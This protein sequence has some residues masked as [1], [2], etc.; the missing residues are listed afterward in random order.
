MGE[1]LHQKSASNAASVPGALG[2][3]SVSGSF[4]DVRERAEPRSARSS[5]IALANDAT[6]KRARKRVSSESVVTPPSPQPSLSGTPLGTTTNGGPD[7]ATNPSMSPKADYS[8]PPSLRPTS[9]TC[10]WDANEPAAVNFANLGAVLA[11]AGHIYRDGVGGQGLLF[12]PANADLPVRR[13]TDGRQLA[14]LVVDHVLVTVK[15][16]GKDVRKA[17]PSGDL[18]LMLQSEAFLQAFEP[19]DMI[20]RA[21]I[22]LPGFKLVEPGYNDGGLGHRVFHRGTRVPRRLSRERI[23]RFLDQM[24]FCTNADRTNAVALALTRVL[25]NLFPGG[26][27]FGLVTATKSHSG[28]DTVIMFVAGVAVMVSVSYER[29]DWAVQRSIVRAVKA[30]PDVAV[31]NIENARLE[32]YQR[33][34]ASAFLERMITSSE[35]LLDAT[36]VREPLQRPNDLLLTMSTNEGSVSADLHNRSAHIHLNPTGN[37]EDRGSQIGNPKLEYLPKYREEIE[38][39][40]HGMIETWDKAG[41]PLDTSVKHPFSTWAQVIGGILKA[42]GFTDFLG[43]YGERKAGDDPIRHRLG[44]L[45]AAHLEAVEDRT[46]DQRLG[47]EDFGPG[48]DNGWRRPGDWATLAVD[49]GV[50]G[51]LVSAGDRQTDAG[52]ARGVG[53]LMSR[54]RDETFSITTDRRQYKLKLQRARRRWPPGDDAKRASTLYRFAVVG[55]EPIPGDDECV[56]TVTKGTPTNDAGLM[57]SPTTISTY[58]TFRSATTGKG[59]VAD[60]DPRDAPMRC[61]TRIAPNSRMELTPRGTSCRYPERTLHARI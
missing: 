38:G 34:I 6:P 22:Y 31:I 49:I 42:N 50:I 54:H 57:F 5:S 48:L 39:E 13:I 2:V 55:S 16:D 45:G 33:Y 52:R 10:V 35:M 32:T 9:L 21:A 28:K 56:K 51:D 4:G 20:T 47:V 37:V 23:E 8:T 19:V 36:G 43:N 58:P 30:T 60:E 61:G 46:D 1:R 40:L 7:V 41:R 15:K 26:K 14:A 3:S 59:P 29:A 24:D 11:K 44:L 18:T 17:I 12:I 27:P 53:S 25:R